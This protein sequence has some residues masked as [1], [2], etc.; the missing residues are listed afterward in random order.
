[1]KSAFESTIVLNPADDDPASL[2]AEVE[3]QIARQLPRWKLSSKE[4]GILKYNV[5][6]TFSSGGAH[7][8]ITPEHRSIRIGSTNSYGVQTFTWGANRRT[9]DSVHEI[10]QRVRAA[11]ITHPYPA[12][13]TTT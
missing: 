2:L 10:I 13:E 1:M 3:G 6:M 12:N 7:V 5:P 4:D 9:I 11:R 8:R